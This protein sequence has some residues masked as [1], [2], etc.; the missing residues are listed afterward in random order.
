MKIKIICFNKVNKE[1]KEVYKTY[2]DKLKNHCTLE[3]IEINEFDHGD[4]KSNMVKNEQ[5]IN[6]KILESKEYEFFLLDI[7]AKQYSSE[8]IAQTLQENQNYKSGKICF[9]IGPSDGFSEDFRNIHKNK[10]SF[11]LIT[12][13]YNLVRIILLEQIYRGFKIIKNQKYHK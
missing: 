2:I 11:G 12:L 6:L 1:Y 7:N 8:L 3:V 5:N 9:I 4:I 10:I 13:P